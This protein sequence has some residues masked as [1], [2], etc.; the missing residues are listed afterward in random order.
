MRV[1]LEILAK[2]SLCGALRINRFFQDYDISLTALHIL[3]KILPLL[4]H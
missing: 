3:T 1:L 4:M 2:C